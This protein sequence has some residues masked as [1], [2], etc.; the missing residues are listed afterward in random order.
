LGFGWALKAQRGNT[1]QAKAA[2]EEQVQKE[3]GYLLRHEGRGCAEK[4]ILLT[5]YSDQNK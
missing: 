1:H 5:R 3:Q 2:A 4:H